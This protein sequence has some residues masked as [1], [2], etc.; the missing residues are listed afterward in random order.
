MRVTST[1]LYILVSY[2]PLTQGYLHYFTLDP[3]FLLTTC[4]VKDTNPLAARNYAKLV[5]DHAEL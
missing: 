3:A 5:V 4:I 2:Y 1:L